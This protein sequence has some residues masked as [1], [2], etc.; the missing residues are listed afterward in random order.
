LTAPA[1]APARRQGTGNTTPVAPR[2]FRIGTQSHEEINYDQSAATTTSTQDL[3]VL[4][5]PPAGFLR[6]IYVIVTGTTSGNA[7]NTTFAANGPYN[8]IDTIVLEDVNSAPI[9]GPFDGWDLHVINKYGGYST[10]DDSKN[11]PVYTA[12]TGTGGTGGSFRFIDRLPVEIVSRDALGALP[13][14]SGTAMFKVRIRLAATATIYG[15]P[16]TA[17]PTVRIR[18]QQ[19]DWWDPDPTDMRGRPLA[20]NPPAVQTTQFW[21]KT[22]YTLAAGSVRQQLERVG[23]LIRNIIFSLIDS[24]SSRSQGDSDFP[25]PFTLQFEANVLF[26]RYVELWRDMIAK[27]YGYSGSTADAANSRDNGV[28]PLPF[29]QDFGF[30]PGAETRRGYLPT[31]AASRVEVQ[32]TIG[33]SGTHTLTVYTND[34]APSNGDDASLTV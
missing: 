10:N 3:P 32:G 18:M 11:S 20:Q 14:K 26:T 29:C 5:I 24:N 22:T 27:D 19:V 15:T 17:A 31:S 4:N 12:T 25:D 33:G 6:G 34:V 28:Y 1:S 7:A 13:N 9:I 16:P 30:K 2:A 8:V 23:N 21:S